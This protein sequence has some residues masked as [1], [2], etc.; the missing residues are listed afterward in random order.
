MKPAWRGRWAALLLALVAVAGCSTRSAASAGASATALVAS[1]SPRG[2]PLAT[3]VRPSGTPTPTPTSSVETGESLEPPPPATLIVGESRSAGEPGSWVW[4]QGSSDAPWLPARAL[5]RVELTAGTA[6]V[7]MAGDVTIE[8][9]SAVAAAAE[10]TQGIDVGP[11]GDGGGD[12][13]FNLAAGDWVVAVDVR[14]ADG[15]GSATYYWH[16]VV[17]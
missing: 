2:T 16:L 17:T 8:S 5:E 15:L 12:P 10:D 6:S 1:P 9:W 3:E 14:F 13:S 11:L 4:A 7:E